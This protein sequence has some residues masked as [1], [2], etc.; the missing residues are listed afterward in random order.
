[1]YWNTDCYNRC[2]LT[3][4]TESLGTEESPEGGSRST[5]FSQQDNPTVL[6]DERQASMVDLSAVRRKYKGKGLEVV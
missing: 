4:M 3:K 1:M 5:H 6:R 2:F